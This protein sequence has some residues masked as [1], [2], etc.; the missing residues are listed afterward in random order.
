MIKLLFYTLIVCLLTIESVCGK[1]LFVSPVGSNTNIGSINFSFKTIQYAIEQA[2]EFDTIFLRKGLYIESVTINSKKNITIVSYQNE[3]VTISPFLPNENITWEKYTDNIYK[4]KINGLAI[5]LFFNNNPIMQA[6]YPNMKEELFNSEN[7]ANITVSSNKTINFPSISKFGT[8]KTGYFLGLCSDNIVSI[9]GN[10]VNSSGDQLSITDTAFYWKS[11]FENSYLGKGK[12]YLI[13]N[14]AFLDTPNEWYADGE[15]LY[16][17]TSNMK[18]LDEISIRNE[19]YA[20]QILN[21]ENINVSNLKIFGGSILVQ[22]SSKCTISN[23]NIEYPVPFHHPWS[24]FERFSQYW[25]GIEVLTVGPSEWTGKGVEIGGENNTLINCHIAHSWGDGATI[26][27]NGNTIENCIIEDCDWIA[28]D[29][30]VLNI[31]GTNH[32]VSNNT[33]KNS[34]RSILLNRKLYNSKII[35][36][37]LS[38]GGTKCTDL[39]L[40]YNYDTDGKN[41]EIAYNFIHDSQSK[42]NGV[43]IYLDENNQNHSLHHNIITNC[44]VG[45]N[46]NKPCKNTLVYH[47]TLYNNEFSMGAWGNTGELDNVRTFNNLTNTDKKLSWNYDAF[48]GTLL[49]S[50]YL[51]TNNIFKDPIN[52]NFELKPNASAINSGVKNEYTIDYFGAL[53]DKG[54]FEHGKTPWKTGSS[55]ILQNKENEIPY[56]ASNLSLVKNTK[57]STLLQWEYVHGFIDS[58]YVQRKKSGET[59][60]KTIK[61]VDSTFFQFNDTISELGEFRYQILAKNKYGFASPSNSVEVFKN[62]NITNGIFLDAENNDLQKGTTITEETIGYLDNKDWIAFKQVDF[63]KELVDACNIR[64]AVPCSYAWQN[65]Q[66]RLDSYMGEIVGEHITENTGGWDKFEIKTFP[67]NPTTG[68]HDIYVKFRG[69]N[70]IGTLDWFQLYNSNG[71]VKKTLQKD[72]KCPQPYITTSEIPVKLFPNP[73]NDLLRVSFENKEL[74]SATVEIYNTIGHKIS[75]QSFTELYPGEIELHVDSKAL[76]LG[77]KSA[78]Y[79]IKVTIES[80]YHNQ[81]TILKYIRL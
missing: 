56:P 31:S 67:I 21:A 50:N 33:L 78:F 12:G 6:S 15:Y 69:K 54:A 1:N 5:Q 16:V 76:D 8:L 63:G 7:A 30:A 17:Y 10:I 73:G 39:G 14:I 32:I 3:E 2:K 34:A 58:Y 37:D 19:L 49:D 77:L 38:Y 79:L 28:N 20:F 36:N 60:Y 48:Y 80:E 4:T 46:L 43:G 68:I 13:G 29:C 66:I 61:I 65:I 71:T 22:E 27:G 51:Y 26:Y 35:H 24:G 44:S 59:E 75:T 42:K 55:L 45:I 23:L 53:P 41:T 70:G 57:D 25:N 11:E 64:Y 62:Q 52:N 72:P 81:E 9:G 47:N 40:I 18:E 74:A